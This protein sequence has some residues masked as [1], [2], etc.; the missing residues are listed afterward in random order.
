M[1]RPVGRVYIPMISGAKPVAFIALKKSAHSRGWAACESPMMTRVRANQAS[2][3]WAMAELLEGGSG[4]VLGEVNLK[5]LESQ[6][7][8]LDSQNSGPSNLRTLE[9]GKINRPSA[10]NACAPRIPGTLPAAG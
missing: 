1:T 7:N 10:R 8:F 4:D 5:S 9:A 2:M 3:Y 6:N